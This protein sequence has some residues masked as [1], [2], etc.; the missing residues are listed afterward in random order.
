MSAGDAIIDGIIA[1]MKSKKEELKNEA[2]NIATSIDK[3][4]REALD[5]NSPSKKG[6]E[7]GG[8]FVEGLIKGIDSY[9]NKVYNSSLSI[10]EDAVNGLNKAISKVSEAINSDMDT[11]PIIRP[12]LDLSNISNGAGLINSMLSSPSIQ[13]MSNLGAISYG[14]NNRSNNGTNNDVVD[15]IDKL[16]KNIGNT[17][18]TYNINGVTYDDGSAVSNAVAELI[19]AVNIE[20]RV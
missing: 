1:G 17:G 7:I 18:D 14:M 11:Q 9:S 4:V 16:G 8:Y 20:R 5:I 15:A 6:I 10:G 13:L 2:I 12:V 3:A 19:R